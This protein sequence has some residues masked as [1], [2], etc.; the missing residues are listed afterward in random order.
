MLSSVVPDTNKQNQVFDKAKTNED[1][2]KRND[3]VYKY[4][5]EFVHNPTPQM[6]F[7]ALV[8]CVVLQGIYFYSAFT[9]FYNLARNHLM[10]GT[11]TMINYIQ[12]D[13][14]AHAYFFS[15]VLDT[16]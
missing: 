16:C 3:R 8:A 12:R 4:Y 15:Q 5:Q 9:F 11:S 13:E 7:R 1:V 14:V 6:F 2:L 10:V